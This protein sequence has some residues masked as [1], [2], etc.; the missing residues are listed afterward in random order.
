M[1]LLLV[2]LVGCEL[3]SPADFHHNAFDPCCQ[4]HGGTCGWMG[5]RVVPICCDDHIAEECRRLPV[6]LAAGTSADARSPG[7]SK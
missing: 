7:A 2:M 3:A 4:L 1:K 5:A 6:S